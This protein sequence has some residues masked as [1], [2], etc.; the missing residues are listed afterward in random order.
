M[1]PP[2]FL[3]RGRA[4]VHGGG[5]GAQDR[6]HTPGLWWAA[7][8][9]GLA[10]RSSHVPSFLLPEWLHS[11]TQRA[12]GRVAARR[13]GRGGPPGLRG[14]PQ[15]L[16]GQSRAPAAGKSASAGARRVSREPR[17]EGLNEVRSPSPLPGGQKGGGVGFSWRATPVCAGG[18][19]KTS[20]DGDSWEEPSSLNYATRRRPCAGCSDEWNR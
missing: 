19:L 6:A 15:A 17:V 9:G 8:G 2:G 10:P 13:S 1:P 16:R 20:L 14:R 11:G 18:D 7:V 4:R 12:G 5:G 3:Q